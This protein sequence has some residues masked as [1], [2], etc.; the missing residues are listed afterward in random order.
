MRGEFTRKFDREVMKDKLAELEE[1]RAKKK[2]EEDAE[3]KLEANFQKCLDAVEARRDFLY[4]RFP[5]IS[6]PEKIDFRGRH[7]LFGASENLPPGTLQFS[8]R[9]NE[10]RLGI[11]FEC[12]MEIP[13]KL[14]K[15]KDYVTFPSDNVND[16]KAKNF[17]QGKI[18][19][20]CKAYVD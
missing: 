2:K 19:E 17:V 20:F 5:N 3:A 9:F 13:G 8:V 15:H 1:L 10:S 6:E 14:E 11:I 16:T 7:F 18:L 12:L 4:K